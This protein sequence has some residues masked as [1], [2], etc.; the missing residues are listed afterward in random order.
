M[1]KRGEIY[2]AQLDRIGSVQSGIRPVIVVQNNLGNKHST[3]VTIIPL[4]K[5]HGSR[6]HTHI[7]IEKN[8]TNNLKENSVALVESIRTI[9]MYNLE[10]KVGYVGR[11]KMKEIEDKM[12]IQL[13]MKVA[14]CV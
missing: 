9:P 5:A 14:Y 1:I 11:Y 12:L 2:M 6:I 10:K 7:N 8:N 3:T 13:G 4:T